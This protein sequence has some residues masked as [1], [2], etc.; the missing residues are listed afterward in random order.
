MLALLK[1]LRGILILLF[2]T[3]FVFVINVSQMLS[4]IIYPFHR[5]AF[6]RWNIHMKAI[7]CSTLARC[8]YLCGNNLHITGDSAQRENVIVI[9]NHQC[10]LDIPIIWMWALPLGTI[11]WMKWFVKDEFKYVPGLGWGLKFAHG[12]FV[13]RNWSKDADS[14]KATFHS[15][16]S[17][18]IPFWI[19]IFPEGTRM[20]PSKYAASRAYS[21]RK[22]TRVFDRVLFP[23]PKGAWATLQGLKSK[24][25][26]IYD[27]HIAFPTRPPSVPRF[28]CAG[29][30]TIKLH[31][32][33]YP[34][35]VL[36]QNEREFHHWIQNRFV[37]KDEWLAVH[38]GWMPDASTR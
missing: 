7:Y 15:I 34:L 16:L 8:C 28:F 36:P 18:G 10:Y 2:L 21:T 11:G 6:M 30:Y 19:A 5:R 13:K 20:K 3:L 25:A 22:G 24:L 23:R 33:R 27:I 9:A 12:L 26:A 35:E 37:E 4:V 32:T 29:G 17:A 14:V 31:V 38:S 1:V